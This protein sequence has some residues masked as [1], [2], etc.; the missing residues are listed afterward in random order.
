MLIDV[1]YEKPNR[2][3][4]DENTANAIPEI[5]AV[6][7]KPSQGVEAVVVIVY[8]VDPLSPVV[9]A[10]EGNPERIKK[11]AFRSVYKDKFDIDD[12]FSAPGIQEAI[13][14]YKEWCDTSTAR[15]IKQSKEIIVSTMD[16]LHAIATGGLHVTEDGIESKTGEMKVT[17]LIKAIQS[18]PSL[19]K[20]YVGARAVQQLDTQ[21]VKAKVKGETPLTRG[22][23]RMI[24]S[25]TAK[26]K[27]K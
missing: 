13:N 21:D 22:E 9:E 10:F 17:E 23:Q 14:T 8:M 6:L 25:Q 7:N 20:D 2:F 16:N 27:G 3:F 19:I 5:R 26:K 4:V 12:F 18:V 1:R 15:M 11:E 24:A